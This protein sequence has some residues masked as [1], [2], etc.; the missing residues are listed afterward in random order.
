MRRILSLLVILG[1]LVL[2]LSVSAQWVV[3]D[4]TSDIHNVINWSTDFTKWTQQLARM[5]EQYRQLVATYDWAKHVAQTLSHP[6]IY[7]VLPVLAV[8]ET[9]G[10]TQT[11]EVE[12]YRRMLE[13]AVTYSRDLGRLYQQIYGQAL[14]LSHL[15]PSSP[16]NWGQAARKL[17]A[18]VQSTD[19]A[20]LETLGTVSKVNHSFTNIDGAGGTYGRLRDK[21]QSPGSTPHQTAQTQAMASLYTAQAVDKNTQVLSAMAAMEAQHYAQQEAYQKEAI[22]ETQLENDY[23]KGCSRYL[24]QHPYSPEPWH[25]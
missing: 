5:T 12:E 11:D 23:L 1:L 16:E 8:V 2:P 20:I 10:L 25:Q 7:S 4:P 24:N 18:M 17:N 6:S 14:D 3:Y 19:A 9:S 15:V 13:G 22:R 21:I